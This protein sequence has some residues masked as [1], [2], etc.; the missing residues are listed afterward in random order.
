MKGSGTFIARILIVSCTLIC[1]T[2]LPDAVCYAESR[3]S[4]RL[5]RILVGRSEVAR[6]QRIA[7]LADDVAGRIKVMDDLIY[8]IDH[9][10]QAAAEGKRI[11]PSFAEL[12]N[13][14]VQIKRP[15]AKQAVI[16][17]L[18]CP[19]AEV[20]AVAADVLGRN[21]IYEAIDPLK[22]QVQRSEFESRYGFRFNLVL[23][24]GANGASRR[25]RVLGGTGKKT[26]RT[27]ASRA[28]SAARES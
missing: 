14:V 10:A 17:L 4:S 13:V 8:A 24:R 5:A 28:E 15:Q 1:M 9:H 22:Q 3:A 21:K 27:I 26:G 19:H 2:A 12:M 11:P 6:Q 25:D 7:A 18:E 20:A 23:R 16:G